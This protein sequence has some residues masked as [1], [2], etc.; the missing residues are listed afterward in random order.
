MGVE[1][2]V[3]EGTDAG[4]IESICSSLQL[5]LASE[6]GS[7]TQSLRFREGEGGDYRD[8]FGKGFLS[9]VPWIWARRVA[10]LETERLKADLAGEVIGL[11]DMHAAM[12]ALGQAGME[13]Y[14]AHIEGPVLYK[15]EGK[16]LFLVTKPAVKEKEGRIVFAGLEV[17]G[18]SIRGE[19]VRE[20][21]LTIER[22]SAGTAELLKLMGVD[23]IDMGRF[24]QSSSLCFSGGKWAAPKLCRLEG[25]FY[26][27]FSPPTERDGYTVVLMQKKRPSGTRGH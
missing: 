25:R 8:R 17:A 24:G 21:S 15:P 13:Q 9:R 1:G 2:E 7:A 3:R 20:A 27:E 16:G 14:N 23:N 22:N 19:G 11:P 26:V 4:A 6:Y 10:D 5:P 18:D 12:Y